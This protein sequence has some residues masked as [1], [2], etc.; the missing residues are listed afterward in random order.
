MFNFARVNSNNKV[1]DVVF[2][3]DDIVT[4]DDGNLY[5]HWAYTHL[6]EKYPDSKKDYWVMI[7]NKKN[8]GYIGNTFDKFKDGFISE[9]PYPSWTLDENTLKW[10][11]PVPEPILTDEEKEVSTNLNWNEEL[12]VWEKYTLI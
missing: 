4:D 2:V 1:V 10:T 11:P 8:W 7:D 6:Y 5:E 3:F 12:Q 9:K